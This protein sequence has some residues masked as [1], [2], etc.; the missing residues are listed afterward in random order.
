MV[1]D[2]TGLIDTQAPEDSVRS[3]FWWPFDE[4]SS[5]HSFLKHSRNTVPRD[6]VVQGTGSGPLKHSAVEGAADSHPDMVWS[7]QG[8]PVC[9]TLL[10]TEEQERR[11]WSG[12]WNTWAEKGQHTGCLK[13]GLA[14]LGNTEP[15]AVISLVGRG[16]G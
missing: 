4:T 11:R 9:R 12:A 10:S 5:P 3:W 8:Q 1:S 15:M 2:A 16:G 13:W 7:E 6:T 14:G